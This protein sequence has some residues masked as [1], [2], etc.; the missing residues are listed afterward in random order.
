[1][2]TATDTT[3]VTGDQ[4]D[5]AEAHREFFRELRRFAEDELAELKGIDRAIWQ[6]ATAAG[7]GVQ[8]DARAL[9]H[10]STKLRN[11][12]AAVDAVHAV[13]RVNDG[14]YEAA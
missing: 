1:M 5:I 11:A 10:L 4:L 12:V 6:L 9:G 13:H 8:V 2:A 14:E 3:T 7:E